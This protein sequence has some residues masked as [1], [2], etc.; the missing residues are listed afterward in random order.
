[1]I[2]FMVGIVVVLCVAVVAVV[3]YGRKQNN[4]PVA[5]WLDTHPIRN[6]MHRKH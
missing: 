6:W 1:M 5:R 2:S 3:R 4:E